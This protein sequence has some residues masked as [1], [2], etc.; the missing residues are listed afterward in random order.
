MEFIIIG[1]ARGIKEED[2]IPAF[3]AAIEGGIK[4]LEVTMN[5]ENAPKIITNA[6]SSFKSRAKI[7]AGTVIT[8]KDL[9]IALDAGAGYIVSPIVN[10][11]VI[12]FCY[13]NKIPVFPGAFTPTEIYEAWELGATMVKVF[14][15]ERAGGPDY[16][17]DIKGPF[18]NIKLL[19]CSGVTAENLKDYL[20]SMIDGIAIGGQLFD[21]EAILNKNYEKIKDIALKFTSQL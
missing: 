6:V 15:A 12:K 3:E 10:K 1:I 16:I 11:E 20:R 9:Q 5:T 7:G 2:I 13:K 4:Y 8:M 21:K 17:R 14:P 19:A 18:N